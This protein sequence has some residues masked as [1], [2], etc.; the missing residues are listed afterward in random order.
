MA[1]TSAAVQSSAVDTTTTQV[2]H[3]AFHAAGLVPGA[4]TERSSPVAP[5]SSSATPSRAPSSGVYSPAAAA[6]SVYSYGYPSSPAVYRSPYGHHATM[7][8]AF[9][10]PV[11][12]MSPRH[13]LFTDLQSALSTDMMMS[14]QHYTNPV[15]QNGAANL[16]M[17]S[18]SASTSAGHSSILPPGGA[19]GV[20]E[21]VLVQH[22]LLQEELTRLSSL[23]HPQLSDLDQLYREQTGSLEQ[24]R[25]ASLCANIANPVYKAAINTHYDQ[26]RLGLIQRVSHSIQLFKVSYNIPAEFSSPPSASSQKH[27]KVTAKVTSTPDSGCSASPI[28][29]CSDGSPTRLIITSPASNIGSPN[30]SGNHDA[31]MNSSSSPEQNSVSVSDSVSPSDD[32]IKKRKSLNPV[33]VQIMQDWYEKHFDHPYP[34]D[35]ETAAMAQQGNIRPTQVKKW[36]ANKRVRSL[37]TLS[38]NGSIHPKRLQRLRLEQLSKSV[39]MD[40]L[41]MQTA[42]PVRRT[43]Q[44][45]K[46]LDP[47]AVDI[48]SSWY[49]RHEEHP[50]P[51]EDEKEQL[52]SQAGITKLQVKYWFANRRSRANHTSSVKISPTYVN[53]LLS[54]K[55]KTYDDMSASP[56]TMDA[57]YAAAF[58]PKRRMYDGY[59]HTASPFG[60]M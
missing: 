47:H 15:I 28:S 43:S 32:N 50:Y 5:P 38:F 19:T 39:A 4:V 36:M 11:H 58:T 52:A 51:N 17:A 45:H 18:L 33:A 60:H 3:P 37:N 57:G 14:S 44:P 23:R 29:T 27:A 13:P 10:P 2:Y 9:M 49:E 46:P 40:P 1:S 59:M 16:Y 42:P 6:P 35:I 55:R 26:Q 12:A 34:T 53:D 24:Q 25:Y 31:S 48:L 21:T 41:H 20:R 8:A 54:R 56:V 7:P 30:E 22:T